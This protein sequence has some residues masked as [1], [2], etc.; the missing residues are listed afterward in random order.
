MLPDDKESIYR[1][2]EMMV[3]NQQILNKHAV[4]VGSEK[5]AE[6]LLDEKNSVLLKGKVK[7]AHDSSLGFTY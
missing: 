6:L 4:S 5:S 7:V 1:L 2:Y 3:K